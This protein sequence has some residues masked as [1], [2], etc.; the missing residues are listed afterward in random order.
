VE[1]GDILSD[2]TVKWCQQS[3]KV[4]MVSHRIIWSWYTGSWWLGCYIWG[5]SQPRPILARC[6]KCNSSPIN[7]Q[8]TNHRTAV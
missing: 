3:G 7:G 5:R 4:I 1:V 8:C 6:T 2:T